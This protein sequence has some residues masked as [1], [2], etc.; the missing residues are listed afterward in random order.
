LR[1]VRQHCK[2]FTIASALQ[3]LAVAHL[4]LPGGGF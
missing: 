4:K 3:G 1:A 2:D